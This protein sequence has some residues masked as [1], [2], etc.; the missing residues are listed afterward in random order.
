MGTPGFQYNSPPDAEDVDFD[1]TNCP[2][3]T[4]AGV[5]NVQDA[6]DHLCNNPPAATLPSFVVSEDLCLL[7]TCQRDCPML[8]LFGGAT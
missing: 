7:F 6:L 3:F 5:T 1:N 4:T 2:D 8:I